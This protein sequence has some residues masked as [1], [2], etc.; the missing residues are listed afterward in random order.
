MF[1]YQLI[2]STYHRSFGI[3]WLL[4]A[5]AERAVRSIWAALD[6][7]GITDSLPAI[8]CAIP[9]ITLSICQDVD[10]QQAVRAGLQEFA[11][12][13]EPFQISFAALGAFPTP[14]GTS[15]FVQPTATEDLLRDH[16]RFHDRLAPHLLNVSPYYRPGNWL[17]HCSLGVGLLERAAKRA[18]GSCLSL[19]LPLLGQ[20]QSVALLEM[21]I[22]ERQVV[23]GCVRARFSL[24][25]GRPLPPESCP[26][27][28]HCPFIAEHQMD[29]ALQP[30]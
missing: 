8:V 14:A 15:V 18:L 22:H 10:D 20:V 27:P 13:S 30:N 25:D 5:F 2:D 21:L 1:K 11:Q 12:E 9:H 6:Y 29:L 23:A 7:E 16:R 3:A 17:P 19:K 26:K 24:G 4:D 28:E